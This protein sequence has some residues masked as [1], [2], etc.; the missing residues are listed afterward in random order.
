MTVFR[1]FWLLRE[2][3][4]AAAET[5]ARLAVAL[6]HL[7]SLL[8]A[9]LA[10]HP[11]PVPHDCVDGFG[12]AYWC[13]PGAYLDPTVQAGM[14]ILAMTPK[15]QLGFGLTKLREDLNSGTWAKRHRHLLGKPAL[16]LGYRLV[17]ADLPS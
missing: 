4:P 13:R 2:Y 6:D 16:D 8:P 15:S 17:V 5:D 10:I 9:K 12:G 7:T 14:S 3:L 1:D 11:I